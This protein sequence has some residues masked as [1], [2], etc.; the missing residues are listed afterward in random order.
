MK[1]T[2]GLWI[3]LD[4]TNSF[5]FCDDLS[6]MSVANAIA[7]FRS[8]SVAYA[9]VIS[10][11]LDFSV[12]AIVLISNTGVL[13]SILPRQ[14]G[15][16]QRHPS[17]SGG[18]V[19]VDRMNTV[20]ALEIAVVQRTQL[21]RAVLDSE[22]EHVLLPAPGVDALSEIVA[23][24]E[25]LHH[26]IVDAQDS[27]VDAQ[28]RDSLRRRIQLLSQRC[29]GIDA[30]TYP[31]VLFLMSRIRFCEWLI[32]D[33]NDTS[34][35]SESLRLLDDCNS[36]VSEKTE[37]MHVLGI[38]IDAHFIVADVRLALEQKD[39]SRVNKVLAAVRTAVETSW[40]VAES[41]TAKGKA[42]IG[43]SFGR[44]YMS[45]GELFELYGDE[46]SD[47]WCDL[48]YRVLTQAH[49]RCDLRYRVFTQAFTLLSDA[50][51][52]RAVLDLPSA[53]S[54][55]DYWI[56]MNVA[57]V[58]DILRELRGLTD[59]IDPTIAKLRDFM[60]TVKK[61]H[62]S[63][64]RGTQTRRRLAYGYV[65]CTVVIEEVTWTQQSK[66]TLS[67]FDID[68]VDECRPEQSYFGNLVPYMTDFVDPLTLH[69][70]PHNSC[71]T[72]VPA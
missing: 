32:Q 58:W 22:L 37:S 19:C 4:A 42:Y 55:I 71:T 28:R 36:R 69:Q 40:S 16:S 23:C 49:Y 13:V 1:S 31:E 25:E 46:M 3:G 11:W 14:I 66:R 7:S 57:A 47:D 72:N 2:I 33:T 21:R 38:S 54:I 61:L 43:R 24:V 9:G 6:N 30:E 20:C 63:L 67:E 8:C 41:T 12:D 48:R 39:M 10:G 35:L 27:D 26:F 59:L 50:F 68:I 62:D 64:P 34:L 5:T 60:S 52:D 18:V 53:G 44:V 29:I 17:A 65:C 70:L 15:V 56:Y 45:L 51:R